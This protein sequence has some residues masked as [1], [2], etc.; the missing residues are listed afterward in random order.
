[1]LLI[2]DLE[3]YVS[4]NK[5]IMTNYMYACYSKIGVFLVIKMGGASWLLK[6]GPYHVCTMV[7]IFILLDIALVFQDE[8]FRGRQALGYLVT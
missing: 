5:N 1:M 8:E 7:G 6:I 4:S 2:I 3:V